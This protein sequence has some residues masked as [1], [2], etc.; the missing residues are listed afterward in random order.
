MS[1]SIYLMDYLYC[2]MTFKKESLVKFLLSPQVAGMPAMQDCDGKE[3]CARSKSPAAVY[4]AFGGVLAHDGNADDGTQAAG[5]A[6]RGHEGVSRIAN[7]MKGG[8][9]WDERFT[10]GNEANG[11]DGEH[12][13]MQNLVREPQEPKR[14]EGEPKSKFT[15]SN[16]EE[17]IGNRRTAPP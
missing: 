13:K 3:F 14:R 15:H 11:E 17:M 7:V 2:H 5:G 4:H 1:C 8:V 16:C 9:R 10:R 6:G 12:R